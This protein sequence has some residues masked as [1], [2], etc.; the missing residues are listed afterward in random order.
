MAHKRLL[1]LGATGSI[2]RQTLEVA[3]TLRE[4]VQPVG[5]AA[6]SNWE[7]LIQLADAAGVRQLAVASTQAGQLV[8][9][10]RP[11]LNVRY[12]PDALV[13][14]V[15]TVE[16]DV[17]VVAI[18]GLAGLQPMLAA[19]RR[20]RVV[21]FATK[22][23]L[24]A[25]GRLV[26]DTARRHAAPLLPIDSEI[27]AIFQCLRA[28]R[29]EEVE[30]VILTASGGP[31]LNHSGQALAAVTPAQALAHPTWRM[32]RKV[33]VDSATLMN[34]GFEVFEVHWLFGFPISA[35]EVVV[36]PQSVLHSALQLVD[37][38]M[39]GQLS[40]PDMRIPIQYA[41]TYP[42]RLASSVP[43][44]DLAA[45]GQLTFARPDTDRF[46]CLRL[47]Y[48]AA[49]AGGTYPAVLNAADEVAVHAFLGGQIKFLDIPRILEA[50]L[51]A[52]HSESADRLENILA[53][54]RWAREQAAAEI[55]AVCQ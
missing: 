31:F 5:L 21:A 12:G 4:Y 25:A 17:V 27:S 34:K 40:V 18:A 37:G 24:V 35:I 33:S 23:P 48:Q 14:L 11:E 43:R 53:A 46:P 49:E 30:R 2:G 47:A 45:Q 16:A 52:H 13:E 8:R 41:L 32:G 26:M 42:Q 28:V 3:A 55:K 6:A 50:V 44:L 38:S 19:L 10:A 20:G 9:A 1:V 15:E 51:E 39:L 7:A 36:H 54:D 22:E 29:Q